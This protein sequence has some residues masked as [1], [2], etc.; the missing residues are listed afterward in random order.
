LALETVA[1]FLIVEPLQN[2]QTL[3]EVGAP[4]PI[5]KMTKNFWTSEL[6]CLVCLLGEKKGHA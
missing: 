2:R 3:L 5:S 6:F 4:G 1:F